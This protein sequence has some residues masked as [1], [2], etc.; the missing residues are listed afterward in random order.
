[1]KKAR[2]LDLE[3][4]VDEIYGDFDNNDDTKYIF[5][6]GAGCSKSSGIPLAKDLTEKWHTQLKNQNNKT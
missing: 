3:E 1:M 4:F 2:I 5:F 6:L